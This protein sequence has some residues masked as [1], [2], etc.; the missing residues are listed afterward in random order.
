METVFLEL[1]YA[2]RYLLPA[3]M[4]SSKARRTAMRLPPLRRNPPPTEL[5]PPQAQLCPKIIVLR[6]LY[7]KSKTG[8]S[9]HQE[10]R[11]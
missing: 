3:Q 11:V 2:R 5:H 8:E 6:E 9:I 10:T 4:F 7:Q 1:K